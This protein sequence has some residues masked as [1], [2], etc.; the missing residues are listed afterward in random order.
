MASGAITL[1]A[2][3]IRFGVQ[4]PK[5]EKAYKDSKRLQDFITEYMKKSDTA[6]NDSFFQSEK[7]RKLTKPKSMISGKILEII[8]LCVSIVVVAIPE[9]L[10]LAVSLSLAFSIKKLMDQ[11]NLVRKMHSCETM[12]GANFICTDKTGTLTRN[13]M[14]VFK[15]YSPGKELT[16]KETMDVTNAGSLSA[17][18][19]KNMANIKIRE[20]HTNY[21]EN[22]KYWEQLKTSIALNIEGSIKFLDSPNQEGDMEEL[23]TKN[24]TD[25]AFID[26]LY[27]FQSPISKEREAF[28]ENE[29]ECVRRLPFD[30]KRKRMMTC[31]KSSKFPTGYRVFSKGGAEKVKDMANQY[32]DLTDGSIKTLGDQ[33]KTDISDKINSFNKLMLRSLY[34]AYRDITQQEFDDFG[35]S[36][37]ND[38]AI[39]QHD[40]IFVCIFGIRDS[41]RNGVPEAVLKC[42]KARVTVVVSL[43]YIYI[44]F[45]FIIPP[46][47]LI[48][49]SNR[50]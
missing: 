1:V 13:E 14:N 45:T 12:G 8:L 9:G 19:N 47:P 5:D 23:E 24:K 31:I 25:K 48:N 10:P 27:R 17:N 33:E 38:N 42:H 49:S 44:T 41:L 30:S 37:E 7:E 20:P 18:K 28:I 34:I 26:F 32:I 15:V 36:D 43:Y 46:F 2:L 21:F 3:F 40:M 11:N 16:L 22:E 35:K 50:W 39:D 4:Y 29:A 6:N